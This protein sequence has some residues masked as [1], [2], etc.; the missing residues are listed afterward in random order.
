M[1]GAL[2]SLE[3]DLALCI[4]RFNVLIQ[5]QG[6]LCKMLRLGT[7]GYESQRKSVNTYTTNQT[8]LWW[9]VGWST[10]YM[11]LGSLAPRVVSS[12][13]LHPTAPGGS[14]RGQRH[15]KS[16]LCPLV[17]GVQLRDRSPIRSQTS[18]RGYIDGVTNQGWYCLIQT[19]SE[20]L[21]ISSL[22]HWCKEQFEQELRRKLSNVPQVLSENPAEELARFTALVEVRE[23]I[24][25]RWMD[26]LKRKPSLPEAFFHR[27]VEETKATVANFVEIHH[28]EIPFCI[29]PFE[30][31]L[32]KTLTDPLPHDSSSSTA[33]KSGASQSGSSAAT[34][35]LPHEFQFLVNQKSVWSVC[36]AGI[37][38]L[39]VSDK[40][41]NHGPISIINLTMYIYSRFSR[42]SKDP[43]IW[44]QFNFCGQFLCRNATLFT[45]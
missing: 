22:R 20:T 6:L 27:L 14:G 35:V 2:S 42:C 19:W 29:D 26:L 24:A 34:V 40:L 15:S 45:H 39:E 17:T 18:L 13:L 1:L 30:K 11:P 3:K 10:A 32:M 36:K 9:T 16:W 44:I 8:S 7:Q 21:L 43:I 37:L 28:Q 41:S 12:V 25:E 23:T 38:L 31:Q 5:H 33:E 4:S